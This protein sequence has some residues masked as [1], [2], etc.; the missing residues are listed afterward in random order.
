ME[1]NKTSASSSSNPGNENKE[2]N[3]GLGFDAATLESVKRFAQ[4]AS[5]PVMAGVR[6]VTS[7]LAGA[8]SG[9]KD[10]RREDNQIRNAEALFT[11]LGTL[12]GGAAKLGQALSVFE[13]AVPQNLIA[14]YRAALTKLQ[15]QLPPLPFASLSSSLRGLPEG[16]SI[17]PNPVASASLGQVHKGTWLDGRA[18]AV[19][20]QYPGI[21]KMVRADAIQLRFLAP[22]LEAIF[23]GSRAMNLIE[24]HVHYLTRELDYEAEARNQRRF[25]RAWSRSSEIHIPDVVWVSPTVLIT[26]W[27]D[28][29]S[30]REVIASEPGSELNNLRDRAGELLLKFTLSNPERLGLVHGDPHPGNFRVSR[31]GSRLVVL[32]FG[33]VGDDDGFTE[34]FALA[35]IALHSSNSEEMIN[36]HERWMRK[37]WL[38]A[39][40]DVSLFANLLSSDTDPLRLPKFQFSRGW[41]TSQASRWWNPSA[42]LEAMTQVHMPPAALLEH[43][44]LAGTF[45]LC[46]QLEA[47][48]PLR[49]MLLAVTTEK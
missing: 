20:I 23:P 22:V 16:V 43:R 6:G 30:L 45:A 40:V 9:D 8:V 12:R 37:G 18:V 10:Q 36:A 24:E 19:K 28:D 4:I 46:C 11:V 31:D 27:C 35:V 49:K 48:V 41:M 42:G 1:N 2:G 29:V 44:A 34:L 3:S 7:A 26:E 39:S 33:A 21:D 15:E 17:D 5:V 38:D 47:K 13:P 14:P 25:A 32:D